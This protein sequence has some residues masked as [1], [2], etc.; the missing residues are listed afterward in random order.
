MIGAWRIVMTRVLAH[1]GDKGME[2]WDYR[3]HGV[4]DDKGM[5]HCDNNGHGAL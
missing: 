1:C 3:G 2:H 4:F 5:D